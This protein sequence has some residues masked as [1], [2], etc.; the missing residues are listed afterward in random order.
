MLT[1][2]FNKDRKLTNVESKNKHKPCNR[3]YIP[4]PVRLLLKGCKGERKI[5]IGYDVNK[6][7]NK[8]FFV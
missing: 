1:Y 2:T 8:A 3:L 7:G 5:R 6:K 4:N